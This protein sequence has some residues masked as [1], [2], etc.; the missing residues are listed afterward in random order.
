MRS[1]K[2][3]ADEIEKFQQQYGTTNFDFYDLTAIIRKEWII[4]FANEIMDRDLNITWQIPGGTRSEAINKEVAHYLYKSGCRNITYAPESGSPEILRYIKKKISI[5][6]MLKS[7]SYSH[8]EGMNIKLNIMIGFPEEN[9]KHFWQ[10]IGFL[11]R[12]SWAGANDAVPSIFSPYPGSALFQ[13]LVEEGQIDPNSEAYYA[14]ILDTN[15]YT[16][17]KF[18]NKHLS[19]NWLRFYFYAYLIVFFSTN[20]LFRPWRIVLSIANIIRS[21]QE[22]RGEAA[23]LEMMARKKFVFKTPS[24]EF[25]EIIPAN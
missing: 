24:N 23:I 7:I 18:Y 10:T 21:K 20:F 12:A 5:D 8:S 19:K 13:Q 1:P 4:D 3:V 11:V 15:D 6:K 17:T 9:H 14:G 22:S 2:H 16:G 25:Q